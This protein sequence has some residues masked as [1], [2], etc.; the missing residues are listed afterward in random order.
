MTVY[1]LRHEDKKIEETLKGSC[2]QKVGLENGA[3]FATCKFGHNTNWHDQGRS[4]VRE[5]LKVYD[6]GFW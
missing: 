3:G 1:F 6:F 4:D 5:C 2:Y